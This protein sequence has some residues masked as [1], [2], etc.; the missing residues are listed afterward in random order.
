MVYGK[1]QPSLNNHINTCDD[2]N[3]GHAPGEI[4]STNNNYMVTCSY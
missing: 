2:L 4:I 1:N 3:E